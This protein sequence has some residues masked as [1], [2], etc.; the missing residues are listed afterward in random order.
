VKKT[1]PDLPI[2]L[3]ISGSGGL[4]ERMAGCGPDI[5]SIDQSVDLTDGIR[6][7][8]KGFAYQ[9]NLDPGVLFGDKVREGL[10]RLCS[11]YA[12]SD[13]GGGG[14]V[15]KPPRLGFCDSRFRSFSICN[16]YTYIYSYLQATIESRV[17]EVVKKAK[18][19]GVRHIMNLGHGVLPGTPEENV[20][21]FFA[22]ARNVH[23]L[24]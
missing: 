19:E 14:G 16:P 20:A 2:I 9:G 8:G 24:L 6:R 18:A 13:G 1:H 17:V 11:P 23:N 12:R 22:T 21:T 15:P 5:I 10:K 3:Y 4:I 7:G